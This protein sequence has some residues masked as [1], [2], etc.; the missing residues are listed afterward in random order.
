MTDKAQ[1]GGNSASDENTDQLYLEYRHDQAEI[2]RD[3]ILTILKEEG[4]HAAQSLSDKLYDY[5]YKKATT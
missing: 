2:Q 1:N 4:I 5:F 3:A